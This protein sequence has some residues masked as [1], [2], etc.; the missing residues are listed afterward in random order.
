MFIDASALTA[1]VV[2]EP[3]AASFLAKLKA[4]RTRI[5]SSIA[6]WETAVA[7]ARML[8][9]SIIQSDEA[10]IDFLSLMEIET[11]EIPAGAATLALNAFDRY[12]KGRHPARLNMG[13]CFAYACARHFKQ[14][15]LYKGADFPLTDI[16]TA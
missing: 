6:I 9:L 16:E 5:T 8:D 13:D 15:L 11:I 10:V 14:P 4:N 7:V 3:D 1:M 12:G 2:G